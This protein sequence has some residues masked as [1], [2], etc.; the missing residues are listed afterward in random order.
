MFDPATFEDF[1]IDTNLFDFHNSILSESKIDSLSLDVF[2]EVIRHLKINGIKSNE[3]IG[4][5]MPLF[6]NGK[7]EVTNYE[8]Y[9]L[10]FYW[11][12]EYQLYQ[13][14]KGLPD[15]TMISAAAIDAIMK[16]G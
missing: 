16:K 7:I 1:Y 14:V 10:D 12:V 4:F 9:D 8:I 3:C 2:N 15:G 13:Q 6:L 5:K 11:D